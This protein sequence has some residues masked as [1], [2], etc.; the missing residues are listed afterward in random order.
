MNSLL[1]FWFV[2]PEGL[3]TCCQRTAA[4]TVGNP[5]RLFW[6][7]HLKIMSC[8]WKWLTYFLFC[9]SQLCLSSECLCFCLSGI[10]TNTRRQPTCWMMLWPSG[11]RLWAGT[12]QL[13][14]S[15][16]YTQVNHPSSCALFLLLD[17]TDIFVTLLKSWCFLVSQ[18]SKRWF[19]VAVRCRICR[20]TYINAN[21]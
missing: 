10:R 9:V 12:I 13:W 19:S 7:R 2:Y 5:A 15:L 20:K 18:V 1:R 8:W 4:L 11:R 3:K 21:T 14:V 17:S 6:P 16:H